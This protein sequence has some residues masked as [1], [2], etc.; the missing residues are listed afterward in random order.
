[1]LSFQ[2]PPVEDAFVMEDAVAQITE[3]LPACGQVR[4][5]ALGLRRMS[6]RRFGQMVSQAGGHVWTGKEADPEAKG[7]FG[8]DATGGL[9]AL[10]VLKA[11]LGIG[12]LLALPLGK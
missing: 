3:L 4:D 8:H 9:G 10:Y 6:E 12:H 11:A 2:V 7:E 5:V 1:M